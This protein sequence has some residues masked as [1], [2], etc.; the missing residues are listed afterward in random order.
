VRH[1][2]ICRKT[3]F[4]ASAG[5]RAYAARVPGYDSAGIAYQNGKGLE[6]YKMRGKI[7]DLQQILPAP[8]PSIRIGIGHT[9]WATHGAPSTVNAHPHTVEG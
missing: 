1:R 7:H 4:A 5:G 2:R 8:A 3:G 6:I 9:R